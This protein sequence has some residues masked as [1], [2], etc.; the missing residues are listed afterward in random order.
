[1]YALLRV[2]QNS[3]LQNIVIL[4][5]FTYNENV[6]YIFSIQN[7]RVEKSKRELSLLCTIMDLFIFRKRFIMQSEQFK[8]TFYIELCNVNLY[9][10]EKSCR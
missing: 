5:I 4:L 1:M 7:N 9:K 2:R 8:M 10:R 6:M 3:F